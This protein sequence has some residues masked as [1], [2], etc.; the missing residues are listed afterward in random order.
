MSEREEAGLR[1]LQHDLDEADWPSPELLARYATDPNALSEA[2]KRQVERA[3]ATSRVVTDELATL[4]GFDFSRLD[5][6]RRGA[7]AP[8]GAR[9]VGAAR[10]DGPSWLE[11]LRGTFRLRPR[12]LAA[13]T[14][15]LALAI[16]F[17]LSGRFGSSNGS[18]D[19][20]PQLAERETPS[21]PIPPIEPIA[22]EPPGATELEAQRPV[23]EADASRIAATPTP[24][25]TP[26]PAPGPAPSREGDGDG[27]GGRGGEREIL[28]AMTMPDYHP[29]YGL[30]P[31]PG[32][33]WIVRGGDA[34][35]RISIAILTPNHLVRACSASPRL[36]WSLDRLP[37]RGAFH[38]T[39]VDADDEPIVVDQPIPAPDRAGLQRLDLAAL[40]I[41][42]P[43]GRPLRWSIALR[44]DEEAAPSA[45]D[46]GWLR[47][48]APDATGAARL[49]AADEAGRAAAYADLG[50]YSEALAAALDARAA[51]PG[52]PGPER[53][54]AALA[55]Q[56]GFDP[57]RAKD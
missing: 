18:S 53:A 3:L 26:E 46:F 37:T 48:E 24:A 11:R 4:R 57:E 50:C 13:L 49:A 23:P 12:A 15:L 52:D 27:D 32:T 10:G 1:R 34:D 20:P 29:A 43:E 8:A 16:G 36:H 28:L 6:D 14:A 42:L 47:F 56:A 45:F 21:A 55:H 40:R 7:D 9:A 39:I 22:P 5:A 33:E 31:Q 41:A 35:A 51:H 44:E 2:E 30:E 38:L 25:R 54:I 17:A 19:A